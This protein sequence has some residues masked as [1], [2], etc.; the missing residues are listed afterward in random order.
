M[1]N[2]IKPTSTLPARI[3]TLYSE[4]YGSIADGG[5]TCCPHCGAEGRLVHYFL[6]DDGKI[7][8]AM[9]GCIKL[10]PELKS[11][12]ATMANLLQ[13]KKT[14]IRLQHNKGIERKLASWFIETEKI[15]EQLQMNE[16]SLEDAERLAQEQ[17][18]NRNY[19]LRKNHYIK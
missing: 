16:I 7:H 19:W 5:G 18:N 4:D 9:S 12:L 2:D 15:L 3:V 8:A 1:R 11:Y 14:E 17:Y 10:F 13:D 6:C